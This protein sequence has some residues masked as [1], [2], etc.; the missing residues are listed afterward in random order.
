[1]NMYAFL[2]AHINSENVLYDVRLGFD[3]AALLVFAVY[4][5]NMIVEQVYHD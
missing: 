1:M 4:H 5:N 3:A 2:C